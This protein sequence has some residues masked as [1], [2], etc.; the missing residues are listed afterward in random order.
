MKKQDKRQENKE[1]EER[2]ETTREE[3]KEL[4]D[5][6]DQVTCGSFQYA[7]G[8]E[9]ATVGTGCEVWL[10]RFK[11]FVNTKNLKEFK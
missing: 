4:D 2:E 8:Q 3:N 6:N 11:L 10:E 5:M 1:D 7:I 9:L